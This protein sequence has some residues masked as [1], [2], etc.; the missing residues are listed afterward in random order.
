MNRGEGL[1]EVLW[2]S[3]PGHVLFWKSD[4]KEVQDFIERQF[5]IWKVILLATGSVPLILHYHP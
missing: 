3:S 4:A 5:D 1:M 2:R